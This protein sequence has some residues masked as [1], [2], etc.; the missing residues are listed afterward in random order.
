MN[1]YPLHRTTLR[2]YANRSIVIL[3]AALT[4]SA[5]GTIG[6]LALFPL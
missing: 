1:N 5:I 3:I 6:A 4:G 2:H